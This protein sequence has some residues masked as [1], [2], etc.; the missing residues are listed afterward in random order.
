[1]LQAENEARRGSTLYQGTLQKLWLHLASSHLSHWNGCSPPLALCRC[2][3]NGY[4][5]FLIKYRG[6]SPFFFSYEGALSVF[7]KI[8]AGRCKSP[9]PVLA[10]CITF[11]TSL[12]SLTPLFPF[13]TFRQAWFQR[14]LSFCCSPAGNSGEE[15]HLREQAGPSKAPSKMALTR[16]QGQEDLINKTWIQLPPTS[17]GNVKFQHNK[18]PFLIVLLYCKAAIA[19]R[20]G[21]D[22]GPCKASP[23]NSRAPEKL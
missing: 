13:P 9:T 17:T 19:G 8:R 23:M 21:L 10:P 4:V 6:E 16:K 20:T 2:C 22:C 1:M 7:S 3:F 12:F 11:F 18:T 5:I 15:E 14:D